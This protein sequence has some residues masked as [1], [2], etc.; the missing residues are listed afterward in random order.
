MAVYG[1]ILLIR[2]L[3]Q[4]QGI[5]VQIK[6]DNQEINLGTPRSTS[7]SVVSNK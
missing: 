1:L 5:Q 2:N 3:N 6:A 4:Y 7:S